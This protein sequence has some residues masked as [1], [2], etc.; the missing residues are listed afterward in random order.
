MDLVNGLV[1]AV[2]LQLWQ[3]YV[4]EAIT[5]LLSMTSLRVIVPALLTGVLVYYVHRLDARWHPVPI[6]R[7]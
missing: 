3:R 4:P 5:V 7:A 2:I 6:R 1:V